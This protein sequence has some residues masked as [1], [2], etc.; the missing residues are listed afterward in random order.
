MS[1]SIQRDNLIVPYDIYIPRYLPWILLIQQD[2]EPH[3]GTINE[4]GFANGIMFISL[5]C[6]HHTCVSNFRS[7]LSS[8]ESDDVVVLLNDNV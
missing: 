6:M 3:R 7:L 4:M 5:S 8:N 1:E 2:M